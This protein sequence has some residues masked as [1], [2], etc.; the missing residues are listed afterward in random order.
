M[1]SGV[2]Q[3]WELHAWTTD[4]NHLGLVFKITSVHI[5][6]YILSLIIKCQRP[7][8][9]NA[10]LA[11]L[12]SGCGKLC[13]IVSRIHKCCI[14]VQCLLY[15]KQINGIP[16]KLWYAASAKSFILSHERNPSLIDC[17]QWGCHIYIYSS[18]KTLHYQLKS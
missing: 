18:A 3:S 10:M 15:T 6:M 2:W 16:H 1:P 9:I 14:Y 7:C 4:F 8:L 12:L 11:D 5:Y 17:H 13:N